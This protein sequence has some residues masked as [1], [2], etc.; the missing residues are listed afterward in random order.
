MASK[1][2]EKDPQGNGKDKSVKD[3]PEEV[4]EKFSP[5]EEAVSCKLFPSSLL[6]SSYINIITWLSIQVRTA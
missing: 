4:Q 2:T 6:C 1:E 3:E 5:E